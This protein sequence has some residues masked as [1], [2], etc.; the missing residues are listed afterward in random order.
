MRITNN[1]MLR[2]T[3]N[4][5]NGNKVNVND[6]NNQM[7]TQKKIQ[8]PSEDPVVA[9][10]A[11]RF[12]STLSE[13]N[14][15][16]EKNIPDANAWLDVTETALT[17][18]KDILKDIRTKCEYGATG[19]LT[20]DD[21]N[22]ILTNLKKLREQVY[23]EGNADYAGRTV[24]TGYR[25]NCQLTFMADEA[26]TTYNITEKFSLEDI[27]AEHRYYKGETTV[28]TEDNFKDTSLVAD[29]GKLSCDRIR[30]AYNGLNTSTA[31]D[32]SISIDS[33]NIQFTDGTIDDATG[34]LTYHS[35]TE[36][37]VG[38]NNTNVNFRT[39]KNIEDWKNDDFEVGDNDVI[40]IAETGE[41]LL[42]K[43]V[44][45]TIKSMNYQL[46]ADYAKTGFSKGEVR[47]E[48]Y[49]NCTDVSD[50]VNPVEYQK[51]NEDGTEIH[52]DINYMIAKCQTL[53]V[54]T[55]ASDVFDESIG[56]DVDEMIDAM[57]LAI[58]AH[59]KVDKIK[60]MMAQAEYADDESQEALQKWLDAAQKEADYADD[61][62]RKLYNT[63]L[64]NFDEYLNKVNIAITTVG[65]K[66][67]QLEMTEARMSN[68]QL[69]I[70]E[71]K[72]SNEDRELS[73]I[74]IDYTAAYNAYQSSLQAAGK[75]NQNTLL[76]YI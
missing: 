63:Y 20:S 32:G 75:I 40:V 3:S 65:G 28:P 1:I 26:D 11:L 54:N 42:G 35:L 41:M 49:F 44:S 10:R 12:R 4:N 53:T 36:M 52:Q 7:S 62:T 55:N 51:Y 57:K 45:N 73:D 74:I 30:F 17:N 24:F 43:D 59:D 58:D 27:E 23:A 2:N 21:R 46:S 68:Q 71:L 70:T 72:S 5:I 39:Y 61:N 34:K 66:G 19:T 56:R 15:Y 8:R 13:I 9:I 60:S 31:A 67:D 50:P 16:Y 37:K 48:Y 38:E 47:P 64:G 25:T 18:M 76:N 14:Q 22:T 33:L 29:V 69:T 6:L